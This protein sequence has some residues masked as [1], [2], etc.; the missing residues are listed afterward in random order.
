MVRIMWVTTFEVRSPYYMFLSFQITHVTFVISPVTHCF[1]Q[2]LSYLV[3]YMLQEGKCSIL[4][5]IV[6]LRPSMVLCKKQ[7]SNTYLLE[8]KIGGNYVYLFSLRFFLFP[9]LDEWMINQ[10]LYELL[11]QSEERWQLFIDWKDLKLCHLENEGSGKFKTEK[12]RGDSCLQMF[13]VLLRR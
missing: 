4:A 5:K 13:K 10:S 7:L 9:H 8:K 1:G 2:C 12:M 6:F 11:S 3:F